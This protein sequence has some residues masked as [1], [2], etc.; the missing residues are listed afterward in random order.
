MRSG[1]RAHHAFR[2]NQQFFR[3][4]RGVLGTD[5]RSPHGTSDTLCL[6]GRLCHDHELVGVTHLS[7]LPLD[8]NRKCPLSHTGL[9]S[10]GLCVLLPSAP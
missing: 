9:L 7:V 6:D 3:P 1:K 10:A 4:A 8:Q 5:G 2:E